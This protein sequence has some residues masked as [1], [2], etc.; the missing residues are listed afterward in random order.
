MF[1]DSFAQVHREEVDSKFE[2]VLLWLA[3]LASRSQQTAE[4]FCQ[5]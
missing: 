3:K 1:E 5:W 4:W 2:V